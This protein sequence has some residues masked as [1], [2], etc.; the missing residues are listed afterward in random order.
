MTENKAET[1][2]NVTVR[3][4]L[5][6]W[7]LQSL[8]RFE[9]SVQTIGVV[10]MTTLIV[11]L[12]GAREAV[13]DAS[14]VALLP[15]AFSLLRSPP[16]PNVGSCIRPLA[17]KNNNLLCSPSPPSSLFLCFDP[18]TPSHPPTPHSDVLHLA[19]TPDEVSR[20]ASV[21]SHSLTCISVLAS[22]SS[23]FSLR[24]GLF[25]DHFENPTTKKRQTWPR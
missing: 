19:S 21:I 14:G 2:Q 9:R 1:E 8:C 20:F 23:H 15:F 3:A 22:L 12:I 25:R 24:P 7:Q 5:P 13:L 6:P 4:E 10:V 11:A 16:P 17:R 18:V